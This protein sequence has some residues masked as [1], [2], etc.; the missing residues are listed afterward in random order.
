MSAINDR[1]LATAAA[2]T[3]ATVQEPRDRTEV[4]DAL[5]RFALGQDLKSPELFSSAFAPGAELDDLPERRRPG[6]PLDGPA[7]AVETPSK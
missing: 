1:A 4:I 2:D 5:Y 6:A 7:P 3:D